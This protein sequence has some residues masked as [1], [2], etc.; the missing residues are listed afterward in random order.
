MPA[1]DLRGLILAFTAGV[2]LLHVLPVLPGF[3]MA[4]A[5]GLS[6]LPRWRWRIYWAAAVLGFLHG[7]LQAQAALADRWPASRHGEV[8]SVQGAIASLPESEPDARGEGQTVR[9]LFAPGPGADAPNRIRASW[10]RSEVLPRAGECWQLELKLRTPH[11]SL[12]PQ[13]FDYEGWL[14]REGVGAL[15]TVRA[16]E[17]CGMASGYRLLRLRQALVD[18]LRT[19][20]DGH[21]AAGLLVGLTVGDTSGLR[22]ADWDVF[23]LTGTT[24]L[25]AIS[26]LN[27]AIVAGCAFLLLRGLWSLWPAL[28]LRVPAQRVA[29]YGAA[30]LATAY[31][32]LAGFEP[33]VARALYMLLAVAAAAALH[34]LD[35]ASQALALAWGLI[36]AVDPFAV[37]SPGLWLSFGAVS[38]ILYLGSRR[39][40]GGRGDRLAL[41]LQ[42]FLS[43]VLAPLTL[44]HFH[45]FAWAS[46]LINLLAV[47]LFSLLT[48]VLLLAALAAAA[49][50]ESGSRVLQFSADLLQQL[51]EA[52]AWAAETLPQAWWPAAP[53]VAA[54]L[55]AILGAVLLFAPRGLPLRMLG[56]LC[57]L[58]LLQPPVAAPVEGLE[59]TAL[60]VGQG[61]A[62]LV[63]TPGH[64]LL[65]DAGPAFEEG[66]DAGS[67]IVAPYVLGLGLDGVDRLLLSHGDN[68]HA[69]GVPAVRR[70]LRIGD[71]L[72]TDQG[73]SCADGQSWT[74]DGVR[75]ELLHPEPDTW[76]GNDG[77]CVLRIEGPFSVLL[78]GDIERR[79]E[80]RLLRDHGP[81]LRADLLL[82]PHHGSRSSSTEDF[83]AAVAPRVVIHSAGWRSRY[84]HPRPEVVARY[85][86]GS[87]RQYTTGVSGALRVWRQDGELRVE[88]W[89]PG[90]ARWW[91]APARP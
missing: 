46:P 65:F 7:L 20:L 3:L 40:R 77:S 69:G 18:R 14:L 50:D 89:R 70:L 49:S 9:F 43:L 39:W 28:C 8:L 72:G 91:N 52:L 88:A 53:P 54:L 74:W 90:A 31:A 61:L 78:P 30:L 84:G 25:V 85:A 6:A 33:P 41:R 23:R 29:L 10:Y 13:G 55:L 36:L 27:L 63:R 24:H 82:A 37:L 34:R 48:P 45:G 35:R 60:D 2:L 66:F 75:F 87:A 80:R 57:L 5:L 58:P 56:L 51:R 21:P 4:L 73:R 47:P 68:D 12:N 42:L 32:A 81:R 11:G 15:A 83:V 59:V 62:V 44:F 79:A 76:A 19:A 16:G 67:S 1:A 86:A 71:E 26:G 17:P 38:A 22:Q 64:S